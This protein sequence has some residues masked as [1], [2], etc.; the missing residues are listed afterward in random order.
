MGKKTK[1]SFLN[2]IK[3]KIIALVVVAMVISVLVSLL[4]VVKNEK[5]IMQDQ[6][7]AYMLYMA[8][9]E[10]A[11]L[12]LETGGIAATTDQYKAYLTDVKVGGVESSYIYVVNPEGIMKYHPTESK[13]GQPVENVVVSG[14][15]QRMQAG[16]VPDPDCVTYEFKGALKFASYCLTYNRCILVVTADY[17]DIMAPVNRARNM[18]IIIGILLVIVCSVAAYFVAQMI[19][20]PL[21]RLTGVIEQT[22]ALD[23]RSTGTSDLAARKDE[24]G[25]MFKAARSM[26]DNLRGMV[27]DIE[28]ASTRIEGNINELQNVTNAVNSMCTDNSATTEELAAGMEQTAATT[29]SIYANIGYMQTGAKDITALSENGE[30]LSV[31]IMDRAKSLRAK[32]EEATK[33]TRETFD[34]VKVRSDNAI[35]ESKAVSKINELTESIMA[36]SSQTS[37]LALNA[38]IEAARAGEAGRGFAVV[39]T[40]IGSLAQQTSKAVTDINGI[41]GEVN[42]AVANMAGCLEETGD[43]LEK[44]V[45]TDYQEFSDVSEQYNKDALMFKESMN[46]VHVSIQNLTDS[47]DKISDAISGINS[48]VGESTVGVT[49]IAEKTTDMVTNTSHSADLVDESLQCVDQLKDVVNRFTME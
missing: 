44:T 7:S 18:A 49:D 31:E 9:S 38:S 12:D 43:F 47:I 19:V 14:L 4:I 27:A 40:E 32:T 10:A 36:I 34:S 35:E 2:S 5:K 26:R 45:L 37:L 11:K 3:A 23:F 24:V 29:E 13:I 16:D 48:T 42:S 1:V 46:D 20:K 22:A 30:T 39:A 17:D 21:M 41:V 25:V 33:R 15:V 8:K 28:S 6:I